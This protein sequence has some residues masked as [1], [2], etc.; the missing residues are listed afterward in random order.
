MDK[1]KLDWI[2][3][4]TRCPGGDHGSLLAANG[5]LSCEQCGRVAVVEDDDCIDFLDPETKAEFGVVETEN[6]SDHP[7]DGNAM[8][9]IEKCRLGGGMVL[10]AG[11]GYKAHTFPHVI[12]MEIVNYPS[13]DVLAVN[14]RLPFIDG[15][16]DAVFSLDVLEHVNDPF[17]CAREIFRVLRPGGYLYVDVPFLQAEHGYPDHYFNATRS[18]LKRLFNDMS[19]LSHHVPASGRAIFTLH[20]NLDMYRSG[21]PAEQQARL[22][23]MTVDELLQRSPLDWLHDPIGNGLVDHVQ[24]ALASTT[25]GLF[26][27]PGASSSSPEISITPSD[28]PGFPEFTGPGPV[29]G[30]PDNKSPGENDLTAAKDARLSAS[31]VGRLRV[32]RVGLA[33][34]L[35][36]VRAGSSALL[37]R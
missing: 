20:Q 6:V 23:A 9:I 36:Q 10:D 8:T 34:R 18:G 14:Q 28:L 11:S 1:T 29:S 3:S 24:W 19:I 27:R 4:H 26:Q 17:A 5:E 25:Q 30:P 35:R 15:C 37:R 13:V 21:L 31:V 33:R 2:V 7:F 12:Q 32:A 16:F 22:S